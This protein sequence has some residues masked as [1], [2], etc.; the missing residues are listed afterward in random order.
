MKPAIS[1]G[2]SLGEMLPVEWQFGAASLMKLLDVFKVQS[3]EVTRYGLSGCK[4]STNLT[5][6]CVLSGSAGSQ[7]NPIT[8][9]HGQN[10]SSITLGTLALLISSQVIVHEA[11]STSMLWRSILVGL[12]KLCTLPYSSVLQC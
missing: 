4:P 8:L 3:I 2:V 10:L 7:P 5:S 1:F 12:A 6:L 11:P 9:S